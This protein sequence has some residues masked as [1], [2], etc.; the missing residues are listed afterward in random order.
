MLFILKKFVS[1]W[2]MPLPGTLTVLGLGWWALARGRPK[3]GRRLVALAFLALALLGNKVV[4]NALVWP[5]EHRYPA[6][7]EMPDGRPTAV[8]AGCRYVVILGGGHSDMP[9][10]SATNKL[11]FS[12]LERVVEGV[13]I[14]RALPHAGMIV[15]GPAVPG[16]PSHASVLA[17]SAA[18]LGI[19]PSRIREIDQARD[20]EEE[21]EAVRAIVGSQKIALVT[22]AWH[23][24][25]AAALFRHAGVAI[26]PCP[27]DYQGRVEG[28]S[29]VADFTWDVESLERST[30]AV[31]EYLGLLWI[32]LR[33][34]T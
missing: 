29:R 9:G 21:S 7:A 4:S 22:S 16:K 26:V 20:T 11:S 14:L 24:P 12:A 10:L 2:L 33:G 28:F 31:R 15:S 34:K 30:L 13:R 32:T 19:D 6:L 27:T 23:M 5:L 3:L 17:A 8:L 1:F 25:R 18:A